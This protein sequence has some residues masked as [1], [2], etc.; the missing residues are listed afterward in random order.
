[1]LAPNPNA[2]ATMIS[3]DVPRYR[4]K[5]RQPLR[6]SVSKPNMS[7]PQSDYVVD[8]AASS[9]NPECS[10]PCKVY[11]VLATAGSLEALNRSLAAEGLG[12]GTF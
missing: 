7:N 4:N 3:S 6:R 5:R 2:N 1:M 8:R 11:R 10:G 9:K 12:S